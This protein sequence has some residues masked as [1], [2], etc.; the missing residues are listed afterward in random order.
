MVT[1]TKSRLRSVIILC[2]S[3]I[4]LLCICSYVTY[5]TQAHDFTSQSKNMKIT[6]PST[7]PTGST[8]PTHPNITATVFW[9]GEEGDESNDFIQNRSSLWMDDWQSAYGGVDD[10]NDRCEYRPCA[11]TPKENPFYFALPYADT[12]EAGAKPKEQL[13]KIPWYSGSFPESGTTLKNRWIKVERNGKTVYAQWEDV[14]PFGEDD[15]NYV[16]GTANPKEKRAGIDLSPAT[17]SY[18]SI[19]GRATVSWQFVDDK[20]VPSGPWKSIITT[21]PPLYN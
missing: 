20:Q 11:F 4:V 18:L 14:G 9:V 8:Y 7:K 19:D 3:I 12:N 1:Y 13:K 21:S 15:I 5:I 10:P 17:A 16:F 6:S 2:L